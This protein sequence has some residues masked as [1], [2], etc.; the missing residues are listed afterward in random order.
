MDRIY[1]GASVYNDASHPGSRGN[2]SP[3]SSVMLDVDT[4][5]WSSR[6]GL[7]ITVGGSGH[8]DIREL[9]GFHLKK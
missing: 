6:I 4:F 7:L 1:P 9:R 8:G 5:A 2:E 3:W